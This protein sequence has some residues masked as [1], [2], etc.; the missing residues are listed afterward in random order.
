MNS[1]VR[2]TNK[3]LIQ[4]V[5]YTEN[6]LGSV[7]KIL[8]YFDEISLI[9]YIDNN[10]KLKIKKNL[11]PYFK[12]HSNGFLFR[13][14]EEIKEEFNIFEYSISQSS[15]EQIFNNFALDVGVDVLHV[16]S[17]KEMKL[18]KEMTAYTVVKN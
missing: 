13:I 4:W 1:D 8:D 17:K 2:I 11:D 5:F 18:T 12:N 10:F 16:E 9:E 6:F 14:I 15:L 3:K 7:N